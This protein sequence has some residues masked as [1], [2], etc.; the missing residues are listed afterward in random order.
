MGRGATDTLRTWWSRPGVRDT[1]LAFTLL[2]ICVLLNDPN[3]MVRKYTGSLFAV[4]WPA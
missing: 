1:A 4:T 2:A 3:T